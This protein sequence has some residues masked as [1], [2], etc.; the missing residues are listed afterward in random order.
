MSFKRT[1]SGFLTPKFTPSERERAVCL[2]T[3][4]IGSFSHQLIYRKVITSQILIKGNLS[5]Q[6]NTPQMHSQVSTLGSH[7]VITRTKLNPS[8][9]KSDRQTCSSQPPVRLVSHKMSYGSD[10]NYT[11]CPFMRPLTPRDKPLCLPASIFYLS[12]ASPALAN[13]E[14]LDAAELLNSA[15]RKSTRAE[16]PTLPGSCCQEPERGQLLRGCSFSVTRMRT[17]W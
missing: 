2:T 17:H 4:P 16:M 13:P 1:C 8:K 6:E 5:N 9:E 10:T 11:L 3:C 12:P 14:Q 7:C 15:S